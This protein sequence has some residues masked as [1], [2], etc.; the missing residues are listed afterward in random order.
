LIIEAMKME[1][2]VLADRAGKVD[3]LNVKVGDSVEPNT[4]FL[5]LLAE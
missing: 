4:R 3:S 5:T 2:E 1:S